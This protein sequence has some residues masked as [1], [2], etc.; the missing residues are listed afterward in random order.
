MASSRRDIPP[1]TK[2]IL[3]IQSLNQCAFPGCTHK[4]VEPAAGKS[5]PV[6]IGEIGHIHAVNPDGARWIEGL[7][8]EELNSLD[9]LILLCRHHH[10]IVDRQPEYYTAEMLRQWKREHEAGETGN[11]S[12]DLVIVGELVDDKIRTE[13]EILR[14]SRFFEEFD[15]VGF[16]L[17]LARKVVEEEFLGGSDVVRWQS[18]AWCVRILAS[19]CQDKA[20]E[21]L[22]HV[23]EL[24]TG[25]ESIIAKAFL[26]AQKGEK[27]A[28]LEALE[29]VGSPISRSAALIIVA[30]CESR[31]YAIDWLKA[32]DIDARSLDPD[33]KRTLIAYQLSLNDWVAAHE[34]LEL[35]TDDDLCEAPV[36]HHLVAL[37][38]LLT[39][40]PEEIR[41]AVL[42]NP[43]FDIRDFPFDSSEQAIEARRTARRHFVTAREVADQLN[44]PRAAATAE[45]YALWLELSDPDESDNG[46][47]RLATKLRDLTTGLS[48][49]RFGVQSGIKMDLL[50]IER[51]I[52]R[53][54]AVNG[55]ITHDAALARFGLA[56]CN[57]TPGEVASYLTR[58]KDE[59]SGHISSKLLMSIQVDAFSQAGQVEKAKN[60][61]NLLIEEGIS[62]AE[63]YRHRQMIAESVGAD[64]VEGHRKLFR[65]TDSLTDLANLVEELRGQESWDDLCVYGEQLF[66]RTAALVDA[67]RY[68]LA[69][70]KTYRNAELAGFLESNTA[71]LSQSRRLQLLYCD[72]LLF[73]GAL[74]KARTEMDKL[75]VDWQDRDYRSLRMD[76]AASMG[77]THA[78]SEIVAYVC[79]HSDGVE[80]DELI[81]TAKRAE[82]LDLPRVQVRTLVQEAVKKGNDDADVLAAAYLLATRIGWDDEEVFQWLQRAAE[83][84]GPDG[85]VKNVTLKYLLDRKPERDR[86]QSDL[87]QQLL[88][89]EIPMY[90]AGDAL[91][92]TLID[93]MLHP[94][95]ANPEVMDPRHRIAVPAYDEKRKPSS[96]STRSQVGLDVSAL[97]T[98]GYLDLLEK[99][100]DAFDTV[101]IPHTTLDWLLIERRNRDFH[102]KTLIREARQISEL[103]SRGAVEKLKT[104]ATRDT[105]L[106]DQI[107][108]ELAQL[109][110]EAER[111]RDLDESQ[112]I[113]VR[114]YPIHRIASLIEHEEIDLTDRRSILSSCHGIVE[115]LRKRGGFTT[116]E[117]KKALA[118]LRLHDQPWPDKPKI[119]PG[120]VLYLDEEAV[121]HLLQLKILGKLRDHG[122]RPVVSPEVASRANK[123]LNYEEISGEIT[124]VIE[125]I[126]SSISSRIKS[127]K[128]KAGRRIRTDKAAV[129][130]VTEHPTLGLFFLS[131]HCNAVIADDRCLSQHPSIEVSGQETPLF[132]TLDLIDALVSSDKITAEDRLHH[133]TRLR[134]AGYI[135]V[136]V[137]V[138]ELIH[139]LDDASVENDELIETAE[140]KAIRENLLLVR[141]NDCN[142]SV[143]ENDWPGMLFKTFRET[144]KELWKRGG[145]LSDIQARSDWILSQF[146]IR[147]WAHC[148]ERETGEGMIGHGYRAQ[149]M[150]LLLLSFEGLQD[151][152]EDYWR[153]IEDRVLGPIREQSPELYLELVEWY[154]RNIASMFN[155]YATESRGN[156][157][158]P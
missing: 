152:K 50:A 105:S 112:H 47:K 153:W 134:Q 137:D 58:H 104:T 86:Q 12:D 75:T 14:K 31:Q 1:T 44:L 89:G 148:F 94:F 21:Y 146:D 9:N 151:V 129:P 133:R 95:L 77:D 22:T 109:I 117:T 99:A 88:H 33:G 13:T 145:D 91:N 139:H 130:S 138:D 30:L 15:Q 72:S 126:R 71:L 2:R 103:M 142:L 100:L 108:D 116:P 68:A 81:V 143:E 125:R 69:L 63:V 29:E 6:V 84:S 25:P 46:R 107:G 60:I 70:Y 73:E 132:T 157:K 11:L 85:P 28:A 96:L 93:L 122:L 45:E 5:G 121:G 147:I 80:A 32:T 78:I 35:L 26:S 8:N 40:V 106:S 90:L 3:D 98:L 48:F 118:Y 24:G 27:T 131:E 124:E 39:T 34:S 66:N 128:V 61:L 19:E 92:R 102:Q 36:L 113:V 140:L 127:G 37:T 144:I 17:T 57:K 56:F 97:L 16:S 136:P 4:L 7:T 18:L 158:Q 76:L 51:E 64:P 135:F 83:L 43:P 115:Y 120:A 10:V 59:L 123:L 156:G 149:I 101:H 82:C 141:L 62:E 49:V 54:T 67:E 155:K 87:R 38:H 65:Q 110:A 114:S 23:E 53:Q 119:R 150:S 79:M 55:K 52:E 41:S 74:L 20:E 111:C 42:V 154:R